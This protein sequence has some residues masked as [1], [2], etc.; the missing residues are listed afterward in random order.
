MKGRR[1]DSKP[2]VELS[3]LRVNRSSTVETDG[4]S[5]DWVYES[6]QQKAKYLQI[7]NDLALGLLKQSSMDDILWM[8]A[9][10]A[11]ANLGF[12]DCVIYLLDDN[13]KD[14]IQRAAHGPKNPVGQEI[15]DPIKIPVGQGIVGAV[16]AS[17]VGEIVRDA[18]QD[19]RYI[20]DDE[21]RLSEIAVPIV[22]EDRVIGVIDSEHTE[23]N[24]YTEEHLEILTTIASM[25]S[26]KIASAMIIER[27]NATVEQLKKTE[28]AL[29]LG[30][31][32]YRTLYDY[33]PSMFFTVNRG[34]I[35]QS[36]NHF[37]CLQLGYQIEDLMG[38]RFAELHV[39]S[40][41]GETDQRIQDCIE[42]SDVIHRWELCMK[43]KEGNHI[44]VRESARI[45]M[46]PNDEDIRILIVSED[47][48]DAHYLAKELEFQASHDAL[49]GLCNRRELER[50]LSRAL[51][52]S[53]VSDI[54][55]VLCFIDLDQFK[56][57]N[58]T[59]GH[60]AG[61]EL[62]R[63]LAGLFVGH[64]RKSDTVARVGGDEFSVLM[65]GCST[66]QATRVG[67]TLRKAVEDY[68]FRWGGRALSLGISLGLVPITKDSDSVSG[69]LAAADNACYAAKEA[70]RNRLHIYS[71]HDDEVV[72]RTQQLKWVA[73]INDAIDKDQLHLFYQPIVPVRDQSGEYSYFEILL[74]MA[75]IDGAL[76][77]PDAFL[78]A[79]E[80]YG[81]ATKLDRWVFTNTLQWFV[82]NRATL[83]TNIMLSIN[84]S[85]QSLSESDFLKFVTDELE[86]TEASP[87]NICI[88]ITE[89]AV[90]A[91]LSRAMDF[92]AKLKHMGCKFA[93]DDFGSGLSSFA[94]LKNLE[95]DILKIDGLFI[96]NVVG[97]PLGLAMVRSIN[98]VG[99]TL[100]KKTI[101][102][103]VET[104]DVLEVVEDI[105]VDYAQGNY[106]SAPQPI[107]AMLTTFQVRRDQSTA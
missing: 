45:V 97:D 105:G 7:I 15:L 48:T 29:R 60:V 32:R 16:A 73:T 69:V 2:E 75:D 53:R 89:T 80:R 103:F 96:K 88:E 3:P 78:P 4:H 65:E 24:F 13:G 100:G 56:V 17:G 5:E 9:K 101:A 93:L 54:E 18:R 58:D 95:V 30:E 1:D 107:D 19:E 46:F 71:E 76:T 77:T 52:E 92:I 61:D 35:I 94:Y 59:C 70:G 66:E 90:I 98:E 41:P 23:A 42:K 68:R 81:L 84:V 36:A 74:R 14:L 40:E 11:I 47:I 22:H 99:Q 55:H 67:E 51:D 12:E 102:E 104:S 25:A 83:P 39:E 28:D 26:T 27:L 50:R 10:S 31:S 64:V 82:K 38:L 91:N 20:A 44:W 85:G 33:H 43:H 21:F 106:F 86:R 34:G 8:V 87:R 63:Q 37:A 79:A 49:T 57:I 62:L 72:R 6:L